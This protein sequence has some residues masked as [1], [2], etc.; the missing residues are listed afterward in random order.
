MRAE[1][2]KS[3]SLY[4]PYYETRKFQFYFTRFLK[5]DITVQVKPLESSYHHLLEQ[6]LENTGLGNIF[7]DQY[8]IMTH[9]YFNKWLWSSRS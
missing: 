8:L 4:L 3:A 1:G 5:P 6:W 2:L 7:L 9:Y